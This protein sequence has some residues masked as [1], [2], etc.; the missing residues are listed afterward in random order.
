METGSLTS[1][2]AIGTVVAMAPAKLVT[3]AELPA[4]LSAA[5]GVRVPRATAARYANRDDFPKPVTGP[6]A[7][8]ARGRV[9]R[10]VDVERWA[11]RTLPLPK[12]PP[13]K[14]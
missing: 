2:D 3:F 8:V 1:S 9:W 4:V 12:G 7:A 13:P 14:E 10:Q 5:A 11:K 6:V